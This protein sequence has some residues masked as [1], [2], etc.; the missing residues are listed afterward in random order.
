MTVSFVCNSFWF[1]ICYKTLMK[2][3][4]QSLF[5]GVNTAEVHNLDIALFSKRFAA[6]KL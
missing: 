1:Y 6:A 2:A 3:M 5:I 4:E